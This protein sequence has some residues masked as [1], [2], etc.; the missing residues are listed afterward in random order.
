[1]TS[2][3]PETSHMERLLNQRYQFIK[4]LGSNQLGQTHL[5]G[6][7]HQPG[8][9]RCVVKQFK[10]PGN[11]PKTLEFSLI[12]LN[13]KADTLKG[14]GSHPQIPQIL[15]SF[16]ESQSFYLVEEFIVGSSLQEEMESTLPWSEERAIAI[17]TEVL[18]VLAF[19]HSRGLIHRSIK[20]SNLIRRKS[21]NL[22]VLTGFGIFK[23]IGT[24]VMKSQMQLLKAQSNGAG[25]YV[26]PEQDQGQAHFNSDLYS[27][28]MI[29]IQLLTGQSLLELSTLR[30]KQ[31]AD[32]HDG[33][34]AD[35]QLI[36]LL[37]K[38]IATDTKQRYQLASSVLEDLRNIKSGKPPSSGPSSLVRSEP[39]KLVPQM[40][41]P[42]S[43]GESLPMSPPPPP[44][45]TSTST[46]EP[47]NRR[48]LV[49]LTVALGSLV[50][51]GVALGS[52][53]LSLPGLGGRGLKQAETHVAEGNPEQA[54]RVY[55]ET[56]AKQ[57][58]NGRAYYNRAMLYQDL[59][60]LEAALADLTQAI[61]LETEA[62]QAY[63][64]R[65][66][67]R[68]KLGDRQGARSDYTQVIEADPTFVEAYVNRGSVLSDLGDD[69]GAI[70][71]Y[72]EAL[73]I[74]PTLSAAY[75]NRC[76]SWSNVGDQDRA[77]AD[78]TQA[79][80]LEPTDGFAYQNRG[81]ARRKQKD[82]QGALEDYNIAIRLDPQDGVPYHNRGLTRLDLGDLDGAIADFGLAIERK[83]DF[84]LAYY[85]RGLAYQQKGQTE[86]AIADFKQTSEL[87][88]TMGRVGCYEDAQYQLGRLRSSGI[89]DEAVSEE[90]SG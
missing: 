21:D 25:V 55:G 73:K 5:V 52:S 81:L 69:K 79:I 42:S 83:P 10:L 57:P 33:V 86:K 31:S 76:L 19:V 89:L 67:V 65:G 18:E 56:I 72:T 35:S 17:L 29:A 85:D 58:K 22:I 77:I 1:M 20:P 70:L 12:L 74:D 32:W 4:T 46:K 26:S 39:A 36:D 68:F 63:Y 54:L 15:D 3:Q 27:L 2:K 8:H 34:K 75:L 62:N 28:G 9:P 60:N 7:T 41:V 6:D 61:A 64:Q 50:L 45:P 49:P 66:N 43:S 88:L 71:D 48:Y 84:A 38:M 16:E 78:C 53:Y 14:V 82:V 47:A 80:N 44:P 37:D 13:K 90:Q 24:Q 40:A 51:I 23:E 30:G 87:C 11:N 59:G